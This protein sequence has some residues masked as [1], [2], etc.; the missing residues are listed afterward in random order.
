[1]FGHDFDGPAEGGKPIGKTGTGGRDGYAESVGTDTG[2]TGIGFGTVT[3]GN[4]DDSF[5]G[6][7]TGGVGGSS[8]GAGAGSTAGTGAA[9]TGGVTTGP[10][11]TTGSAHQYGHAC[12]HA[13]QFV[14]KYPKHD[15][16]Q[17]V[18]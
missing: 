7:L 15:P 5:A 13:V 3:G 14:L 1:V 11:I 8:F 2:A 12:S 10:A 16:G 17:T 4:W 6:S 18:G 9:V